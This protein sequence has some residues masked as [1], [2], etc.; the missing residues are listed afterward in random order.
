MDLKKC[1][2]EKIEE[3][4]GKNLRISMKIIQKQSLFF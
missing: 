3:K 1:T 2:V 4:Q